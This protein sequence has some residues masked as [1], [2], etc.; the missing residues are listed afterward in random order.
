MT[1]SRMAAIAL[2]L[3]ATLL[4]FVGY[5]M[6]TS[7]EP[8]LRL[9]GLIAAGGAV[10]MLLF[11]AGL[12]LRKPVTEAGESGGF[13]GF[14]NALRRL[15][16]LGI[17]LYALGVPLY[18]VAVSGK[19]PTLSLDSKRMISLKAEPQS[20]WLMAGLHAVPG[21]YCLF[22]ALRRRR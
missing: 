21:V 10:A 14:G 2:L 11:S 8:Y 12:F 7:G 9:V 6:L 19:I 3:V 22:L 1:L 5:G 20:F 15:V 18:A 17:A 4:A 13:G 16:F